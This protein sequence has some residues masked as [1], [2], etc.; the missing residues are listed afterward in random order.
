MPRLESPVQGNRKLPMPQPLAAFSTTEVMLGS[1]MSGGGAADDFGV[2]GLL[3]GCAMAPPDRRN[4]LAR[5]ARGARK[6]IMRVRK[7]VCKMPGTTVKQRSGVYQG[8]KKWGWVLWAS[9]GLGM[10][11]ALLIALMALAVGSGRMLLAIISGCL[12]W[13]LALAVSSG[14]MLRP[15]SLLFFLLDQKEPK[16]QVFAYLFA[17]PTAPSAGRM[18]SGRCSD[19]ALSYWW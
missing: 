19:G 16:N 12:L 9:G 7:R 5:P 15:Y 10:R 11:C 13:R 3:P 4:R 1:M 2:V 14:W 6:F 18:P 17:S 8:T